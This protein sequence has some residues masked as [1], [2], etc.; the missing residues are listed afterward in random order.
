MHTKTISVLSL[1]NFKYLPSYAGFLLKNHLREYAE[2]TLALCRELNLPLLK[3]LEGMSNEEMVRLGVETSKEFLTYLAQN[4]AEEQIEA[5]LIR[6]IKNQLPVIDQKDVG[7][8]DI[9]LL[10]YVRK[11]LFLY[12]MTGYAKDANEIVSLIQEIDLFLTRSETESTNTFI[13][14]LRTRIKEQSYLNE[15]ITNTSPGLI[16]LFNLAKS[17]FT[18]INEAAVDF[19]GLSQ[20]EFEQLGGKAIKQLVHPDDLHKSVTLLN[21]IAQSKEDDTWAIEYRLKNY[22]GEYIWMN[23]TVS[24]FKRGDDNMPVEIIGNMINIQKEKETTEKLQEREKELQKSEELYKQ[25]QMLSHIGHYSLDLNSKEIYLTDELK[26]ICDLD[27]KKEVFQYSE[28]TAMRHPDDAAMVDKTMKRTFET[29][30]PFDF[31]FR[32]ITKKGKEK[33]VHAIGE[34]MFDGDGKPSK[35][36]GT[37]QDVTERY[38]ILQKLQLNGCLAGRIL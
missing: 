34:I 1:N 27:L 29:Y 26:R 21:E 33:T 12:F 20:S 23:N 24:V 37:F 19:F 7:A 32:I 22:N 2:Q 13:D 38:E 35:M 8:E 36:V 3:A 5:S 9:T 4:K 16:Y 10:T 11:K 31:D 18:F 15:K 17:S 28:M 6:W 30:E 25:A 14:L